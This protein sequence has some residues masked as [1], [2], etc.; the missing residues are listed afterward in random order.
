MNNKKEIGIQ[1]LLLLCGCDPFL[2]PIETHSYGFIVQ[3]FVLYTERSR[4]EG[5]GILVA[6][7]CSKCGRHA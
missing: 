5:G 3:I 4:D 7:I 6:S 1:L 2:M